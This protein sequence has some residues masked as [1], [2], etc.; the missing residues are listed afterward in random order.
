MLK[1]QSGLP[2]REPR[3]QNK[4]TS[5]EGCHQKAKNPT[6]G[7]KRSGSIVRAIG[8]DCGT[9]HPANGDEKHQTTYA[10]RNRSSRGWHDLRFVR[11]QSRICVSPC[12]IAGPAGAEFRAFF[13]ALF[14]VAEDAVDVQRHQP[15]PVPF[16]N[17]T[18]SRVSPSRG[19]PFIMLRMSRQ[20]DV[21]LMRATVTPLTRRRIVT[22]LDSISLPGELEEIEFLKKNMANRQTPLTVSPKH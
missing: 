3:F 12:G 7:R 17:W 10:Q 14:D 13:A 11:H 8:V 20:I 9:I 4:L 18:S 19:K 21:M 2:K 15:L 6:H 22:E 16:F 5:A 1:L